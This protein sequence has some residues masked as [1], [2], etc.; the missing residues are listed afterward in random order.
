MATNMANFSE[1]K[2]EILSGK[3]HGFPTSAGSDGIWIM[4]LSP[5]KYTERL[6]LNESD[7]RALKAYLNQMPDPKDRRINQDRR[8]KV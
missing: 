2:L 5:G 6:Y 4:A 1:G 8:K 7:V 3:G